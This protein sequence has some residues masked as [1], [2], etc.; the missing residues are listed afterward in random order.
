MHW[1][2]EAFMM[3][4]E[5][6]ETQVG[7]HYTNDLHHIEADKNNPSTSNFMI[8]FLFALA[9]GF[10]IVRLGKEAQKTSYLFWIMHQT[11]YLSPL[12]KREPKNK[13]A[14]KTSYINY[15]SG[16]KEKKILAFPD[17]NFFAF[18]PIGYLLI[19]DTPEGGFNYDRKTPMK[20]SLI[21]EIV[22]R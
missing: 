4:H 1:E 17:N 15:K 13:G 12:S 20:V 10:M 22:P 2:S 6:T 21:G 16:I 9:F 3:Y 5:E 8:A 14:Q 19:V 11:I 7:K 18:P